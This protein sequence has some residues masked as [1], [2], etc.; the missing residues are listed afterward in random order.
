MPDCAQLSSCMHE[1]LASP[2]SVLVISKWNCKEPTKCFPIVKVVRALRLE[3]GWVA[4]SLGDRTTNQYMQI[5]CVWTEG[6]FDI[7][8]CYIETE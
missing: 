4:S 8:F 1:K 3:N 2:N 5:F 6:T 7:Q